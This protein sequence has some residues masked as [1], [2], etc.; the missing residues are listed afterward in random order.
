VPVTPRCAPETRPRSR[1]KYRRGRDLATTPNDIGTA[2]QARLRAASTSWSDD[3]VDRV[4]EARSIVT[5]TEPEPDSAAH[6]CAWVHLASQLYWAGDYDKHKVAAHRAMEVARRSTDP[7]AMTFAHMA[8]F[9][10]DV[11]SDVVDMNHLEEA[12]RCARLAT[13]RR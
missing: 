8:L 11:Y 4:A 7:E 3:P 1:A 10:A 2:G 9:S 13:I 6:A 12:R 5:L